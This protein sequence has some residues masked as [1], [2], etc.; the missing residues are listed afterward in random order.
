MTDP[1][2]CSCFG[3]M[4]KVFPMGDDGLRHTPESCMACPEKTPCLRAAIN[5]PDGP[6][7]Q[8]EKVDRSYRSGRMG[9]FERWAKKKALHQ[10]KKDR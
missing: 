3:Q 7:V 8:E 9:F 10:L 6:K 2:K 5:G 4:E 1:E